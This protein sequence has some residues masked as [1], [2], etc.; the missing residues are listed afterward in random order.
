MGA[1]GGRGEGMKTTEPK[2]TKHKEFTVL[3]PSGEGHMKVL[4]SFKSE[5]EAEKWCEEQFEE[6]IW[7]SPLTYVVVPSIRFYADFS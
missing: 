3:M 1:Q 4:T 5:T 6:N 2:I 7:Q